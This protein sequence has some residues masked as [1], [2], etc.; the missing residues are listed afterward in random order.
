MFDPFLTGLL[1]V[2]KDLAV[3]H[4]LVSNSTKS[5]LKVFMLK[6]NKLRKLLIFLEQYL[7]M[8]HLRSFR[9]SSSNLFQVWHDSNKESRKNNNGNFRSFT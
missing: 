3:R 7:L 2:L 9:F 6:V 8:Y 4:I 5:G 1:H